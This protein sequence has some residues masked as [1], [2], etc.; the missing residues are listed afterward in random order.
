VLGWEKNTYSKNYAQMLD[1][2]KQYDADFKVVSANDPL[3]NYEALNTVGSSFKALNRRGK[4]AM[5]LA[6]IGTKPVAIAMAWYAINNKGTGI[7]YDFIKKK[8][9]RS[10][11]VGKIHFWRYSCSSEFSR[12]KQISAERSAALPA[13]E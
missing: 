7:I 2:H 1:A 11:G 6:P 10:R 12:L 8:N 13:V 3:Q 5:H 9:K 4:R